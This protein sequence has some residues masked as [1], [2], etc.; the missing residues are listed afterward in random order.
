MN[1]HPNMNIK[2]RERFF[3]YGNEDNL[4]NRVIGNLCVHQ[5]EIQQ[6]LKSKKFENA[7]RHLDAVIYECNTLETIKGN[8]DDPEEGVRQITDQIKEIL[9]YMIETDGVTTLPEKVSNLHM[10]LQVIC[11][12]LEK[13]KHHR[14]K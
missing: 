9:D 14:L 5:W 6:S 2:T 11:D 10:Y 7:M 3:R 4:I 8:P 12:D 1:R 13:Y